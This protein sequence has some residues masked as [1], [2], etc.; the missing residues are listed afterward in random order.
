MF[1][2]CWIPA[3][4][5]SDWHPERRRDTIVRRGFAMMC[6]CQQINDTAQS[7]RNQTSDSDYWIRGE[8][9]A[10]S[11]PRLNLKCG[12]GCALKREDRAGDVIPA[13]ESICSEGESSSPKHSRM[14]VS[15]VF[16]AGCTFV[17]YRF[18]KKL[19]TRRAP[20]LKPASV[21][22]QPEP[23]LRETV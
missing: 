7:R 11:I 4:K 12:M 15:M 16:I 9:C 10:G 14:R 13:L 20:L 5:T 19:A 21:F 1:L 17:Q 3:A 2:C 23:S 22:R 6:Q 8:E 18:R